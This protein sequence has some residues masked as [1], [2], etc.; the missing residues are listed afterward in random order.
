MLTRLCSTLAFLLMTLVTTAELAAQPDLPGRAATRAGSTE[1][2]VYAALLDSI[3]PKPLPDTLLLGDTTLSFRMPSREVPAEWRAQ[4]DSIPEDLPLKLEEAS[5]RRR[6][7]SELRLPRPASFVTRT[8]LI[9]IF[10]NGP[11]GWQ[12][13]YQRYPAHRGYM[14]SSPIAF[15][16]DSLNALV[17]YEYR[18]GGL[19]G[20]GEVVWLRRQT[21]DAPWRIR[22][23]I[24]LWIS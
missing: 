9:D 2:A 16:T 10:V 20:H 15:T 23:R 6:P 5:L 18:C 21:R 17:Y 13:F 4:F 24:E 12:D 14:E 11:H 7:S 8:E 3:G 19:C 22:K 1:A